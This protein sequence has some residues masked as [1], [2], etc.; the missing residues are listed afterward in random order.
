MR[1]VETADDAAAEPRLAADA[2]LPVVLAVGRDRRTRS[3]TC[4]WSSGSELSLRVEQVVVIG[5]IDTLQH[6]EPLAVPAHD[7]IHDSTRDASAREPSRDRAARARYAART[8]PRRRRPPTAATTLRA[9]SRRHATRASARR[10]VPPSV[11]ARVRRRGRRG[12]RRDTPCTRARACASCPLRSR[13][14]PR[15]SRASRRAV[16]PGSSSRRE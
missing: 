9:S 6:L 2:R 3:V 11:A 10:R 1:A 7:E 5:G 8:A 13:A 4:S 14:K 16:K 15:R 12:T